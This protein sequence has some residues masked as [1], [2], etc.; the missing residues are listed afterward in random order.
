[1]AAKGLNPEFPILKFMTSEFQHVSRNVLNQCEICVNIKG[2][3]FRY[4]L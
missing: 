3:H 1:M 4:S 2:W